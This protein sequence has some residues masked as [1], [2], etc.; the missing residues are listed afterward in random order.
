M[1]EPFDNPTF[2]PGDLAYEAFVSD[3][4]SEGIDPSSADA[5]AFAFGAT[6]IQADESAE[7]RALL[8]SEDIPF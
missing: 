7:I 5:A 3:C 8:A 6:W 1:L 4:L 2:E